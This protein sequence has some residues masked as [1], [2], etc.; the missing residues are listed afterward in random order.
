MA[1]R[2][3][4]EAERAATWCEELYLARAA[5]LILYGRALGL[6][7]HTVAGRY[8]YGLARLKASMKGI[9]HEY[10]DPLRTPIGELD[11][12]PPLCQNP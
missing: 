11:P 3:N 12:T 8:R 9:D 10:S 7:P 4:H 1:E 6:S 2:P 5:A